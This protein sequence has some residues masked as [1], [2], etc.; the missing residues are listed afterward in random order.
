ME[1]LHRRCAG[2]DV[3]QKEIVACRRV[4]SGRKAGS[5]PCSVPDHDAG[6]LELSTW[7]SDAKVCEFRRNPATDSD[8]MSA[9]IPI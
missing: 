2:L 5:R 1:T 9:A 4:V 6:L 7:L 8:L 3:H